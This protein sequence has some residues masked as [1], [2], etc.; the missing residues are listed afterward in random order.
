VLP[1]RVIATLE[2][3]VEEP[4]LEDVVDAVPE[5][6]LDGHDAEHLDEV[7]EGILDA[8]V[9][10]E[11]V[12]DPGVHRGGDAEVGR[13]GPVPAGLGELLEEV[14]AERADAGSLDPQSL[15]ELQRLLKDLENERQMAIQRARLPPWRAP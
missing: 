3:E 13:Q 7:V 5:I 15:H 1:E 6:A 2:V 8:V 12:G 10:L 9:T 11:D 14:H 4:V